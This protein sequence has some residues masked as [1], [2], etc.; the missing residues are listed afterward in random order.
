MLWLNYKGYWVGQ[1]DQGGHPTYITVAWPWE[2]PLGSTVAF[3][4]G[5]LL[6]RRKT[7]NA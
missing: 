3:V 1:P 5:C 7:Q 6:A 2:I 4:W